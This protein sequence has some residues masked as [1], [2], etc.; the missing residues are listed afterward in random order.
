M[1]R[2]DLLTVNIFQ[3]I[4]YVDG[5]FIVVEVVGVGAG[6][7]VEENCDEVLDVELRCRHVKNNIEDEE[8]PNMAIV[9]ID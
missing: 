3:I 7:R 8:K 4:G 2:K 5:V 9:E 1:K 6:E